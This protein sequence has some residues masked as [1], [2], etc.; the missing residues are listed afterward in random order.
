MRGVVVAVLASMVSGLARSAA[1][2]QQPETVSAE[3]CAIV[4]GLNDCHEEV[5]AAVLRANG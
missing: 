3:I 5:L 4:V 2:A 1:H